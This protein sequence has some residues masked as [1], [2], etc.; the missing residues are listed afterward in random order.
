MQLAP[1]L[2]KTN[3]AY[4]DNTALQNRIGQNDIIRRGIRI[5]QAGR[6]PID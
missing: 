6:L 2:S 3:S 4:T 5:Q 1:T